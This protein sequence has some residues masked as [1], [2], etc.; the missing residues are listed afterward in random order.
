MQCRGRRLVEMSWRIRP[1]DLDAHM[2]HIGFG[3]HHASGPGR[4]HILHAL[5]LT[6]AKIVGDPQHP[7]LFTE[8]ERPLLMPLGL[9]SRSFARHLLDDGHDESGDGVED[10]PEHILSP[11]RI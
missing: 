4:E 1:A 5:L 2:L 3:D 10:L 9:S 11:K 6:L 7:Y 8:S